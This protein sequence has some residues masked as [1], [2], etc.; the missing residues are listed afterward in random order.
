MWDNTTNFHSAGYDVASLANVWTQ[1]VV[2]GDSSGETFYINGRQVGT[3]SGYTVAG[4]SNWLTGGVTASQNF[5][6]IGNMFLYNTKLTPEQIQ[7][8]YY[9][10]RGRFG[11]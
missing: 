9:G 3:V 8:N 5:G 10:L 11:V 6:Y 7:Q 4:N 1:W 2:V